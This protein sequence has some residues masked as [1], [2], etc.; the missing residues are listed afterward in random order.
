MLRDAKT[1]KVIKRDLTEPTVQSWKILGAIRFWLASIVMCGHLFRFIPNEGPINRLLLYFGQLD[2]VAAVMG[3]LVISGFSIAHSVHSN[4]QGYYRRRVIRVYPLYIIGLLAVVGLHLLLGPQVR[5][6]QGDFHEPSQATL[7]G[8]FVFLQGF[9]VHPTNANGPLWTLGVEMFC[10]L[11][12]PLLM[13][14]H[15]R[16]LVALMMLSMI[17]YVVFPHLHI[18]FYSR[19]LFG[20]PVLFLFW[21]WVGGFILFLCRARIETGLILIVVGALA[22]SLNNIGLTRYG[23]FTYILTV[24]MIIFADRIRVDE[25]LASFASYLGELS[26]PL[27]IVHVPVFILIYALTGG[28]GGLVLAACALIGAML[29]YHLVDLPIRRHFRR[30]AVTQK[31]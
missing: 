3:F 7:I 2:A 24:T 31:R 13:R 27:Y 19:L 15:V 20:L 22:L 14:L 12:A 29:A 10:Y 17:A 18:G 11:W 5:V 21:A 8:N 6:L 26:Y 28:P 23:V 16:T 9:L 1:S 4:P 25:R 30:Q